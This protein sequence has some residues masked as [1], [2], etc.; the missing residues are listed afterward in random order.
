M[1]RFV[2]GCVSSSNFAILTK[3][4]R[5]CVTVLPYTRTYTNGL[6]FPTKMVLVITIW[7]FCYVFSTSCINAILIFTVSQYYHY[8]FEK[9]GDGHMYVIA[10][11]YSY[12]HKIWQKDSTSNVYRNMCVLGMYFLFLELISW[13][14]S[15]S[16]SSSWLRSWLL[17][18]MMENCR[19][20]SSQTWPCNPHTCTYM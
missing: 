4:T 15:S 8:Q 3:I 20:S 11:M 7:H 12:W 9:I 16:S 19:L 2:I 5:L 1:R 17:G 13:Y 14:S 10:N 18:M 6:H